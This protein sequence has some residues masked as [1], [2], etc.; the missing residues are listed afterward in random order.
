MNPPTSGKR[1]GVK[2]RAS[3]KKKAAIHDETAARKMVAGARSLPVHIKAAFWR[4]FG[5]AA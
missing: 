4:R 5:L 3:F 1:Y 2:V